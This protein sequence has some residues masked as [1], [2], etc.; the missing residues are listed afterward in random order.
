[1]AGGIFVF[2]EKPTAEQPHYQEL[3][4]PKETAKEL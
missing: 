4:K 3:A 1:M 2:K